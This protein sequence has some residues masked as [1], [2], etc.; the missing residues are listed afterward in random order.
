M[1]KILIIFMISTLILLAIAGCGSKDT[2][3]VT[4]DVIKDDIASP[5][6][7]D[8]LTEMCEQVEYKFGKL[9]YYKNKT[10][11]AIIVDSKS[12]VPIEDFSILINNNKEETLKFNRISQPLNSNRFPLQPEQSDIFF[13]D[14]NYTNN[15][16][17][18]LFTY[19]K[20]PI[21]VQLTPIIKSDDTTMLCT[22]KNELLTINN[23]KF[24]IER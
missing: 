13:V 9:V 10:L 19:D 18:L 22:N 11:L 3:L 15:D 4:G 17:D 20:I 7:R 14:I 12:T 5:E 2:P 1:K 8:V 24:K 6:I 16:G 23:V 21:K